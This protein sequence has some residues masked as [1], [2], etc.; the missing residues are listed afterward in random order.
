M[1]II[2]KSA[3]GQD[4]IIKNMIPGEYEFQQ[5]LQKPLTSDPNLRTVVDGLPGPE[6]FIYPF[7]RTDFPEFSRKNLTE[8]TRRKDA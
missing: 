6:L 2:I 4:F 7:L 8:V 1:L 5:D 3:E